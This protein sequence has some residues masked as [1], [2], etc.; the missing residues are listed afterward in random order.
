M[1][2]NV[3]LGLMGLATAASIG[4]HLHRNDQ[5]RYAPR[6]AAAAGQVPQG[7]QEWLN[8]VRQ[9]LETGEVDPMD[10]MRMAKAVARYAREQNKAADYQ[11]VEMGPDNVG[12]RVRGICVDPTN[13]QKIWA[14]SVSG[15]LFRSTNGANTWQRIESFSTN[16]MVSSIAVL[17]NG[18][19]YVATGCQWEGIGGTGGSGFFG[20]GLFR[21]D[22]D[23]GS[24]TQVLG[25][26]TPWGGGD[27]TVI[28]R[29][30]AHP[31]D[32]NKLL[33]ASSNP[34]ARIY[35]ASDNSVTAMSTDS[36]ANGIATD[37]DISSDGQT[38][39][40]TL[41]GGGDCYRSIDG[42]QTFAK[43][44]GTS[45][46]ND[47][48]Q[49]NLGRLEMAISPDDADHMFALGATNSGRMSGVWYSVDRGDNWFRMWPSNLSDTDPNAVPELDI[50]RDNS[51]GIYDNAIAVRPGHPDEV[52][53]GGVELWKTSVTG[54]PQQLANLGVFPGCFFCVHADVHE[55]VFA[56]ESTCYVGCDGGVF[57]TPNG[58]Q[59]FYAC[60]RDLAITQF[61]SVAYNTA[62]NVGGGTQDNGTQFIDGYGNTPNEARSIGGGDGF[63]ID[64]SQM[65]TNIFFTSVYLGDISRSNDHGN[66]SGDFYDENVPVNPNAELGVGLG[67]FY[68]NFRLFED[69]NDANS[70]YTVKTVFSIGAGDFI[71]PGQTRAVPFFGTVN[72]V[73]Q[74]GSYTNPSA[75]D[76]IFGPWNSGPDS[77]E[78]IDR[79][80]SMFAIGF[81]GSQGVW[82]TREALNFNTTPQWAKLVDNVG[83]N[84]T[85]MEWSANGDVLFYGTDAGDVYRVTGFDQAY[86]LNTLSVDSPG[87]VLQRT[88]ILSGSAVVTG[89]A[90]DPTYDEIVVVTLGGY[91]GSGNGKVKRT[92]NALGASP[93]WTG[94][95]NVPADLQGMPCYD[96]CVHKDN[97]NIISVGTEFGIWVTDNAGDTWTM[98]TNGIGGVP[99]FA[100]RQQTWNW[101]NNP[102]GPDWVKNPNVIY[103]GTHGR[104]IFRTESLV[105]IRPIDDAAVSGV[106]NLLLV[107]N[108]ANTFST[109]SFTLARQGDVT[110]NVYDLNGALVRTITRKNL[111][112]AQQNVPINVEELSTG[113]YLV[114]VRTAEGRT[115]GRMVVAR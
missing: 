115:S 51:Q 29:I 30:V 8:L 56:D 36:W 25:P 110:V 27:W 2:K 39:L 67:D 58:G 91:G 1:N 14:G 26:S 72:S 114:E 13:N 79:L 113:T 45:V 106:N 61:Y 81:S 76:T 88:Q 96:A 108:P 84:T 18:Q 5:P 6:K 101:Q 28:N 95:W 94:I 104:G 55:I 31:T 66:N 64:F 78:F 3:L 68:T 20:M 42:G 44:N 98:Q 15:G 62:G 71:L 89:L 24:F 112:A 70:P 9:N 74:Y 53:L 82:G 80:T 21:S 35:N 103:A 52:W 37:V 57:K 16:L 34:G 60:N 87:Y 22:D 50:F 75:T 63:D 85:C 7:Q 109:V 77:L 105:G 97:G 65:D 90:P 49:S 93:T 38:I 43:F 107:P 40:A 33:I 86:D 99:V 10:H 12:G 48:P 102:V 19:L 32:P 100:M 59:N 41:G 11:W 17:G 23:G 54:Q 111:A 92:M 47:F 4:V 73:T 69:P 83:G 46:G